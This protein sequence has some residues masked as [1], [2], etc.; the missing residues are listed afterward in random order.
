MNNTGPIP[1]LP[2]VDAPA[3]L[4]E[5]ARVN[6]AERARAKGDDVLADAFLSGSQDPAWAIRHEV[7]KLRAEQ[8]AAPK[9]SGNA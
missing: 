2:A 5:A 8:Q 4:M 1:P 3:T 7:N 6:C 9:E